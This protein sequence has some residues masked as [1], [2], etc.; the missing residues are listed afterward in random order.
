MKPNKKYINSRNEK[1]VEMQ[2]K[3]IKYVKL[4]KLKQTHIETY[5]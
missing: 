1:F 2:E 3:N 5:V 4:M